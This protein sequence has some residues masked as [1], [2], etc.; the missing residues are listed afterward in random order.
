M[1][2]DKNG[3]QL[4]INDRVLI[5]RFVISSFQEVEEYVMGTIEWQNISIII[6]LDTGTLTS[7]KSH[8]IEKMTIEKE[9]LWKLE[10]E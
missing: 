4:N 5:P 2:V 8:Q 6:K 9:L 3:E 1:H 7:R 10:N